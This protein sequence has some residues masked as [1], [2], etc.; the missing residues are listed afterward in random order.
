ME[1]PPAEELTLDVRGLRLAARAHGPPDGTPVLALHGWLDNA[2]SF[3]PLAPHLAGMRIVALDLP[4]HGHSQHRPPGAP[5]H[6]LDYT[7]DA[8]AAA[9]ALGWAS[10]AL[11]GHSLGGSV[12]AVLTAAAPQRIERLVMIES[13]GP[14]SEEPAQAP[15]RLARSLAREARAGNRPARRYATLD[16]AVQARRAVG[17]LSESAARRLA[18]RATM[19]DEQGLR[20]RSDARLRWPSPYR[21]TEEQVLA[22]LAAIDVPVLVLA[23]EAGPIAPAEPSAARR[24][25]AL[26]HARVHR[27]P[28][29][30]HLH[31]ETPAPVARLIDPFLRPDR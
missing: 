10:F 18:E 21:L 17:G 20:W 26:P 2:A 7:A 23:A 1:R 24:L 6:L 22:F 16:E 9:E 19:G 13:L 3:D 8:L 11:L 27:L 30:H 15:G 25:A 4:G 31:M 14:L 5:Y 12:A 28:G 29:N